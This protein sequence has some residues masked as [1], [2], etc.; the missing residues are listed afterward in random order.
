M[1]ISPKESYYLLPFRFQRIGNNEVIINECGDFFLA[2]EGLVEK[3]VKGDI[4]KASQTYRDLLSYHII[5]EK[6]IPTNIELLATR[7]RTKKAFLN[8]FT[9]LHIIA[10]TLRCNNKCIYCQVS[11]KDEGCSKYDISNETLDNTINLILKSPSKNLTIEFQG[12]ESLLAFDKVKYCIEKITSISHDKNLTFV[13]CTNL[14]IIDNPI[15][16]FCNQYN[17]HIS[18][19]LDGSEH[20]HNYNRKYTE[21]NSYS[22][23]INGINLTKA[24]IGQESVSALM[25]TTKYSLEYPLEIIHEYI[26]QG[27]DHIFLRELNPYGDAVKNSD[28]ISYSTDE[29]LK[30]YET[31]LRYIIEINKNGIFFVEDFASIILKKMLTPFDS[32]FV[33]LQS[34]A[35]IIN[36]VIVYDYDGNV[37]PSDEARMLAAQGETYFKLGNVNEN[38]YEDIFFGLKAQ[39][40]SEVWAVEYIPG[41]SDCPLQIYCGVDPIRNYVEFKDL[42]GFTPKSSTCKKNKTII[43]LLFEL[44]IE[45]NEVEKIFLSW[46]N[47]R[48]YD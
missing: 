22:S 11:H 34:P 7:Y 35:G 31:A 5:T 15:L 42:I 16:E 36:S 18:T 25:T 8:E 3:I 45:D 13:V 9:S 39:E 38:S 40:L 17:I 47:L 30:F 28:K 19:S 44:M 24:Y 4:K 41:C 1:V 32:G 12:G 6:V 2:S 21:G 20:I 37:Y 46:V 48:D 33:D 23:T 27:F 43:K 29:F 26:N 10:I 14:A